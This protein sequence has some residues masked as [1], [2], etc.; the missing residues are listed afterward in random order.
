MPRFAYR[1][2]GGGGGGVIEAPDRASALREVMRRGEVPASMEEMSG[3]S[4][5]AGAHS[6]T[7]DGSAGQANA[8]ISLEFGSVMSL[9]ELAYFMRELSTALRAGL[10]LIQALKT[11]AKQGR[12]ARQKAM[13]ASIID[14][15]E[16]GKSLSDAFAT[17]GPPFTELVINLTRAGEAS[18]KLGE[19]LSH[20]ADLL[21][22]D[23]K[24]RR[25]LMAAT[26]YPAIIA[27]L[28]I[29]A[30]IVVTTFIVPSILKQVAAQAAT[31]PW[32]TR[33]LQDSA[34]FF[35]SWWWLVLLV[36][37]AGVFAFQRYYAT[38]AGRLAVDTFMLKT[39]LFGPLM[40]EVAV[41]RFTRTLATLT[42]SGIPVVTGLR[43]TK[44]V[45]GNKAMEDVIE[46][47]VEQVSAGRTIAQPME[48]SGY[49]PPMLVQIVN[50]G[51]RS[52]RLEELLAQA[53]QAF[54][55]KTE[56]A[57]KLFTAALP[58]ILIMFLAGLVGFIVL[59][60]LMALLSMQDAAMRG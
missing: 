41:A 42:G 57:V 13:L 45:L 47:V 38:A 19:V 53:A 60:I 5:R 6:G 34:A 2:A 11:I 3:P 44:G 14:Q 52:G 48:E 49:F 12:K 35:A 18:G 40:R 16:H 28:V 17:Q 59:A 24:L 58:P 46:R 32:P 22:K 8:G 50:M 30:V 51:E 33:V 25:S 1:S 26:L 21:D 56:Q 4:G 20:A 9:P 43:I 31:L 37:A 29:G 36:L 7:S 55:E 15:V 23:V 10:P 54:E 27:V 39:P